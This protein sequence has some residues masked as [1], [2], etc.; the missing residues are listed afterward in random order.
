MP[1]EQQPKESSATS[2]PIKRKILAAA[3]RK[4]AEKRDSERLEQIARDLEK[5]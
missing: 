1:R 3:L 5:K 4:S 2:S